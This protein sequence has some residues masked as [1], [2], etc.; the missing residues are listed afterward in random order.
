MGISRC[1]SGPH[2]HGNDWKQWGAEGGAQHYSLFRSNN[3]TTLY[4]V[5]AML[6][7]HMKHR[8]FSSKMLSL[9][10]RN[11]LP[12]QRESLA[13]TPNILDLVAHISKT[14][15]VTP[16]FHCWKVIRR[17]WWNF[18]QNLKKFCLEDSEL[19]LKNNKVKVALNPI[20]RIF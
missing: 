15:W 19:P 8:L 12:W 17:P 9:L 16:L 20:Y 10:W 6:S 1:E 4:H 5:T 11:K 18:R 14:N 3:A 2:R 7:Y 13:K